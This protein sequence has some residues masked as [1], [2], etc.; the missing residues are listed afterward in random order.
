MRAVWIKLCEGTSAMEVPGGVLVSSCIEGS[1]NTD[2]NGETSG[3]ESVAVCMAF[4]PGAGI[5]CSK[6][7][8]TGV[9][10]LK[11]IGNDGQLRDFKQYEPRHRLQEK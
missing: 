4:V 7:D 6:M 3:G 9:G 10:E 11:I 5:D 2:L 8:E 1:P